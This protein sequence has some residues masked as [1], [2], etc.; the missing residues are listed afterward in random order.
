MVRSRHVRKLGLYLGAALVLGALIAASASAAPLEYRTCVKAA[1]SGK[2]FTGK[3]LNKTC[4]EEASGAQIAEGKKNKYEAQSVAEETTFTS[5]TKA[6][7][8]T[9]GGKTVKCKKGVG[10]GEFTTERFGTTALTF[11][12]CG[13]NGSTKAPC[14][15]PAAGAGVIKTNTLHSGLVF[16][17]EAESK[18]GIL[19]TNT[20]GIMSIK[21]GTE[22]FAV[23]GRLIGSVTNSSKGMALT[24]ATTGGKQSSQTFWLEEEEFGPF[25]LFTEASEEEVEATL[26]V[27]DEQGPKGVAA[28]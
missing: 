20:G 25:T 23:K 1:K 4:T 15:T 17:D 2:L 16:L 27:T 24:F 18:V 26:S 8:I 13:V 11:S 6:V 14:E 5:K 21:C 3:Y 22:S 19:L 7:V 9:V 10:T 12:G 28:V